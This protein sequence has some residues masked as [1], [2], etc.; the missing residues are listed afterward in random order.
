MTSRL[1]RCVYLDIIKKGSVKEGGR[2]VKYDAN[3]VNDSI[4]MLSKTSIDNTFD[5]MALYGLPIEIPN[6]ADECKVYNLHNKTGVG[7][8]SVYNV[9]SGIRVVY[10]D[11]HMAYCN[12]DQDSSPNVIEINHCREGRFECSAGHQNCFYMAP[13][14]FSIGSLNQHFAGSCFPT[15]HYHG[16]S[17]FIEVS[18][19]P[20]ELLTIMDLLS[21]DM[22]H[23]ASLVCN[24]NRFFIMRANES[25][26]HIFSELYSIRENRKSGYLKVK[27]LELLL[28]LSDLDEKDSL[29]QIEYINRYH[30]KAIKSVHDFMI[31]DIKKHY[32]ID[33]LSEIFQISPTILKKDFNKV[34]NSSVYAYLKMYRLQE[35]QKLL[36]RTDCTVSEIASQIGYENPNKF[37]TAFKNE[38]GL[39]PTAFRKYIRKRTEN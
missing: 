16:I 28:F 31:Q 25:I 37:A 27:I 32:T 26:E 17:I 24:E 33:E 23:I 39:S 7:A 8:I 6:N 29:N 5:I 13:G 10:N 35:A 22:K 30:V 34:Y 11:I 18:Q 12:K 1:K 15:C 36:L 14:D 20:K 38:Y 2:F 19:L 4:D 21:I 9:L 3:L